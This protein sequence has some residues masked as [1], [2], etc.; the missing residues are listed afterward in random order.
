MTP[1]SFEC[2]GVGDLLPGQH[3]SRAEIQNLVVGQGRLH[4]GAS[5]AA[6]CLR[7]LV[8]VEANGQIGVLRCVVGRLAQ[9]GGGQLELGAPI[10]ALAP[11]TIAPR[12]PFASGGLGNGLGAELLDQVPRSEDA[13]LLVLESVHPF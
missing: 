13:Q 8:A 4:A 3:H 6:A 5:L 12:P 10:L 2:F 9:C 11:P 1:L 7:P